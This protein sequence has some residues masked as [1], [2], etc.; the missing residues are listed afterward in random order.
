MSKNTQF[1][2]IISAQDKAS[3]AFNKVAQSSRKLGGELGALDKLFSDIGSGFSASDIAASLGGVLGGVSLA[4]S[5]QEFSAFQKALWETTKVT[6]ESTESI[7]QKILALPAELGSATDLT[8]GYY[9]VMSAGITDATKALDTLVVASK[10][11]KTSG[12]EQSVAVNALAKVMN[13]YGSEIE[14]ASVAAN[15]FFGIEKLGM[16]NVR[17]LAPLMG[18]MAGIAKSLGIEYYELA[19]SMALITQTSGSAS[20][21]ATR[22]RSL[23]SELGKPAEN[24][25]EVFDAV[26]IKSAQSV[27]EL[28]GFA[29]LL[30]KIEEGAQKSGQSLAEAFGSQEAYQGF[31]KLQKDNFSFVQDYSREIQNTTDALD[32]AVAG[33]SKTLAGQ[34]E[35]LQSNLSNLSIR[36][37]ES[38]GGITGTAL[39]GLNS[40]LSL[41]TENYKTVN[42]SVVIFGGALTAL[43]ATKKLASLQIGT[44]GAQYSKFGGMAMQTASTMTRIGALAKGAGASLLSAFGGPVGVAVTALSAG[45]LYLATREGE[46]E[47]AARLLAEAQKSVKVALDESAANAK[48]F[49][50]ELDRVAKLEL[51]LAEQKATDALTAQLK[52]LSK[53]LKTVV[54]DHQ[55]W[56]QIGENEISQNKAKAAEMQLYADTVHELTKELKDGIITGEEYKK[57][58][59]LFSEQL[60]RGGQNAQEFGASLE[61]M[62]GAGFF[63]RIVQATESFWALATAKNAASSD[64]IGP[65][66]PPNLTKQGDNTPKPPAYTPPAGSSS[67]AS[68][69]KRKAEETKRTLEQ[70]NNEIAKLTMNDAQYQEFELTKK[71]DDL[72]TKLGEAHPKILEFAAAQRAAWGKEAAEEAK[73]KAQENLDTQ[74]GFYDKLIDLGGNYVGM[75]DLQNK[76]ISQQIELWREAGIPE[77]YLNQMQYLSTLEIR[78]DWVAGVERGFLSLQKSASDYAATFE[79]GITSAASSSASAFNDFARSGARDWNGLLNNMLSSWL[80]MAMQMAS[81][82]LFNMIFGG[83]GSM[84]SFGGG[85]STLSSVAG[86]IASKAS[87]IVSFFHD[88]GVAGGIPTFTRAVPISTFDNAPR[89]HDG[90]VAG[91]E[92]PAILK[93]GELILTP[94]QAGMLAPISAMGSQVIAVKPIINIHN[95]SKEEVT[96]QSRTD[97]MGNPVIDVMIGNMAAKQIFATPGSQANRMLRQATGQTGVNKR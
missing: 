74:I 69:A 11:A 62:F 23:M 49:A 56:L 60:A 65:I 63:S 82:Q 73:N 84:F 41:L 48:K 19:G 52:E 20:E 80:D 50:G 17:E 86:G 7:R 78:T 64:F 85:G 68:D 92:V 81:T 21:S 1:Q 46:A 38:F 14:D 36:A 51:K 42:D 44:L 76:S 72:K 2:M 18:D 91:D 33:Y 83:I 43:V 6:S 90:G 55:D 45:M 9:Q 95:N 27:I 47:K 8:M 4:S 70:L 58:I 94:Q 26:G 34:Y 30:R 22:L 93:K 40:G 32:K 66:R 54:L 15:M 13:A 97:N 57:A 10:T 5:I 31:I 59:V 53:E 71:I 28:E 29:G 37:G 12:V 75:L 25:Q 35:T 88:G 89:F 96:T 87:S 39:S 77:H 16:T 61:N 67:G 3:P 79:G 24:L